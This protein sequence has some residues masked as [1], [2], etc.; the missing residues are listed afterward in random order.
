MINDTER[1]KITLAISGMTCAACSARLEKVLN[2]QSAVQATVNLATEQAH[3]VYTAHAYPNRTELMQALIKRVEQA[4]FS[5]TEWIEETAEMSTQAAELNLQKAHKERY[6]IGLSLLLCVPFWAQMVA[7]STMGVMWFAPW[8]EALLA[9]P[10]QFYL[11]RRFHS[12]AYRTIKGGGANMDVLV[13]LGTNIS[14]FYSLYFVWL[15]PNGHH[16][17]YFEASVTVISLVLLGKYLENRAKRQTQMALSELIALQPKN[18]RVFRHEKWEELPIT[19]VRLN[20]LCLIRQGEAV[21]V[22]GVVTHGTIQC[23]E[24]FLTG[25]AL[26]VLK[27][28]G[29]TILSG[30]IVIEG[31]AQAIAT[32]IGKKT[33]LAQMVQLVTEAQ[34]SKA[35]IQRL[36]DKISGIFVPIVI[37][38]SLATF[39]GW[40]W[41]GQNSTQ[42]LQ[43]ALAVLVIACPCALGLATPTAM[44][45]ATGLGAKQGLIAHNAAALEQAAQ[46]QVLFL[47]KTGTITQGRPEVKKCIFFSN[48]YDK[49]NILDW[50]AQLEQ[51]SPHPLAQA[52]VAYVKQSYPEWQAA[53]TQVLDFKSEIGKGIQ[54]EIQQ[55]KLCMGAPHWVETVVPFSE[56]LEN[57]LE[58]CKTQ[59][60]TV[61]ICAEMYTNQILVAF[62]LA[63]T[64]RPES[65]T[66]IQALLALGV[67]P[68]MLTGDQQSAAQ[69]VAQHV[70]IETVFAQVT[71][72]EKY[73][74]VQ[75]MQAQGYMV[76]MVGDGMNDA[77][78]LTQAHVSFAMGGG[79][80]IASQ[81][82]D[83]TLMTNDLMRIPMTI[84]LSKKTLQII[85]Q[86]L[87]FAFV[88]NT[89][90]IFL[91]MIGIFNPTIAGAAMAMSSI[92]VVSNSL[93]LKKKTFH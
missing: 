1:E 45:V 55:K 86:N 49:K 87:F 92:S 29:D 4:G 6:E 21:P 28:V 57:F 24:Q 75:K 35:P 88:Y 30:S 32:Q 83:M 42:G 70:G 13:S 3:V 18:A 51:H 68:I 58:T 78:A 19:Q 60:E 23:N 7:M 71:P 37:G 52:I 20:D 89:I 90:G 56:S 17:L 34:G 73:A 44:M 25:E 84:R 63:D 27:T 31:T 69:A 12:G 38:L 10:V 48:D 11:G 66:A 80:D 9:F 43:N 5:A 16:A 36:A 72:Q 65:Q 40:W 81:N 15:E 59:G 8:I 47:D 53:L 50:C 61:I 76:G 14:Y 64:I 46:L 26:P 74:H 93:R 85:R 82:A 33:V 2:K 77:A 91:A 62:S 54:G 39:L 67:R 79:T 22:D 41:L